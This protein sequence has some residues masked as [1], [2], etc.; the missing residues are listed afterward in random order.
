MDLKPVKEKIKYAGTRFGVKLL[1]FILGC[2]VKFV[3][4]INTGYKKVKTETVR[5]DGQGLNLSLPGENEIR[6]VTI[7]DVKVKLE[8]IGELSTYQG[9]Y[10]ISYGKKETRELLEKFKIP[11][12]TNNITME[13][14]GVVK[15]GYNLD[16]IKVEL[17]EADKNIYISI[18]E[19]KLNDN[20]VIWDTV[21][22]S[23]KNNILNP[24]NFSQYQ[25]LIAEIEQKGLDEAVN[26]GIYTKAEDNL[27]LLIQNF[28]GDFDGYEIVFM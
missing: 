2:I 24:I 3:F 28:L 22:V 16:D 26:D 5:K 15:I 6:E 21:N 7:E 11:G 25:E 9:S 4:M 23:E 12:T 8:Q 19:A 13:C 1:F 10:K 20:Y 27:K 17:G 14:S 18:P